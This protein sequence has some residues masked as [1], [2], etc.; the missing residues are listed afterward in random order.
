MKIKICYYL[1]SVL[2]L[3]CCISKKKSISKAEYEPL[4]GISYGMEEEEKKYWD[5]LCNAERN[6]AVKDIKNNHIFY[7]HVFGMVEMYRSN[8]EMDSLL[9]LYSIKTRKSL[10]YCMV[11]SSK[12]NCYG[13]KMRE[14]IGR[15]HGENFID[16]LRKVAEISY[17]NKRKNEVFSFE[18]CDMNSRYAKSND[19]SDALER[20][21]KDFWNDT[22]YP[23]EFVFRKEKDLYSSMEANFIL[24]KD[25][26]IS[27]PKVEIHFQNEDNYQFS[28]YFIKKLK[29]F[30]IKSKW[31]PATSVGIPVNS[32]MHVLIFFK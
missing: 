17:V 32:E 2:L 7:T 27:E 8:S 10:Y 25:G 22:E 28:G 5:S 14:E 20:V 26:S 4:A 18:E 3:V 11:P 13:V 15:R 6:Q 30:V 24:H 29:D 1:A 21:E 9:A 16:S 19:Y 23:D 12:Q 31:K